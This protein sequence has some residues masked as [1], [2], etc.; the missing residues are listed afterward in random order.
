[1][2]IIFLIFCR[3]MWHIKRL[4][5]SVS[6]KLHRTSSQKLETQILDKNTDIY[7]TEQLLAL[8]ILSNITSSH[9]LQMKMADWGL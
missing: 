6:K 2:N 4:F 8:I 9:L 7:F 1:M 3:I 5:F